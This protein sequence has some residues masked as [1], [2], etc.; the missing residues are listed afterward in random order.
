VIHAQKAA[1]DV[2]I[3]L[4]LGPL[5]CGILGPAEEGIVQRYQPAGRFQDPLLDYLN[6]G[7]GDP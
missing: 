3:A 1:L 7:P 2:G 6:V 5:V 4:L